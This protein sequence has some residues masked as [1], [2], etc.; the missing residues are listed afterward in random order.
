MTKSLLFKNRYPENGSGMDRLCIGIDSIRMG[1]HNRAHAAKTSRKL[2]TLLFVLFLGIGQMWGDTGTLVSALN[3]I[4]SGDTYYITAL[5]SSKYYTVPKTTIDGQ[6]FTCSEGTYNSTTKKLTPATGA[7]EFVFT[8]VSNVS[9]AYYIY[10]TYLKK[11][12]VATGSK[13]FGY[14]D[15]TSSDYGYWTFSS[16][17]SGGFSGQFSVTHSDKSHY[18]RAYNN[19][20][21]C[22]DGASNNG[23]Y[24]FK[25]DVASCTAPT[26][27]TQPTGASYNKNATPSA[28]S[29]TATGTSLTY[30]WYSN[31]TNSTTG[32]S[33]ISGATSSSYTPSTATAG[34]KYY[35][36]I[37]SSS[38]CTTTS[39]IV[40]V[41]VNVPVSSISL[42]KSSTTIVEDQT[43]TLTA[44]VSP[45]DANNKNVNWSSDDTGV[46]TVNSSG[47][48][49]AKAAGTATITATSAADDTKSAS[50]T[51]TVTAA[52]R[53]HFVDL[54]HSTE[55][56]DQK[57]SYTTPTI[58]DKA[59]ATSGTCEAQHYHFV[60]WITKEKYDDGT[61]ITDGDLQTPT[62]ASNATYYAVWAKGSDNSHTESVNWGDRY[63]ETTDVEGAELSI[64]TSAKVTHNKGTNNTTCKFYTTGPGI[65]VYGGGNF[66]VTT[67]SY[68]SEISL[69][70]GT[71]DGSNTITA[72]T[73]TYSNGSWECGNVSTTSV[74]FS[75]GGSSGNRRISG[76][77]VTYGGTSYSDYIAKCC[78][79]LASIN[80]S[81]KTSN[82][83][84]IVL[85]W[86]KLSGVDGT[87]PYTITCKNGNAD[88]G[89]IGTVDLSGTKATCTV[90]GLDCSTTYTFTITAN[91]DADHCDAT[92]NNIQGTTA[93][94]YSAPTLSYTASLTA[95]GAHANPSWATTPT[96][97]G[98]LTYSSSNTAVLTVNSSTGEVTPVGAGTAH[99]IASWA[100]NDDYC[101][102][103]KNS[104]DITV[105]GNVSVSFNANGGTGTMENQSIQ[106]ST[107]TNLTAN[108]F[109]APNSCKYF[110]GWAT[111]KANAD[112]ETRAYTD[113]QEVTITAGMELFAIW[114]TYNYVVTKGT[115]TGAATFT[116]SAN[117]VD[118]GGS[119]TV[120]AT[121]DA[122]HKG[123][124]QVSI[125]PSTAGEVSG[126]TISNIS[127]AITSVDVTFAAKTVYNI[128]WKVGG[129]ALKDEALENV[130]TS[131][132]EGNGLEFLPTVYDNAV[133]TDLK[134]M[135][136][137]AGDELSGMGNSAP[138]DL[139]TTAGSEPTIEENVTYHAVFAK[140]TAEESDSWDLCET[141]ND[142]TAGDY[143]I[144]WNN[145][146]YLPSETTASKNPA[147]GSGITINTNN[148]ALTNTVTDPMQWTFAGNNSDGW[149][150]RHKKNSTTYYLGAVDDAQGIKIN[151][152]EQSG[153]SYLWTVD[154]NATYGMRLHAAGSRYLA[155]LT[156]DWRNYGTSN[157][158][159]T[160]RLYRHNVSEAAYEDYITKV[161][162]LSSIAV[163][164]APNKTTYKK[165][166]QLDLTNMVV[167]ATYADASTQAVTGYTVNLAET[168]LT[169]SN[170]KFTVTYTEN[171]VTKTTTQA[172]HV[173]ALSGIAITNAP[174]KTVYKKGELVDTE[175]MA[176]QATWGGDATDKIVENNISG[177]TI[178]LNEA[179]TSENTKYTVS[180]TYEEVEQTAEQPIH[181]Y[182]LSGIAVTTPPTKIT[183]N[184]GESFDAT[185]MV[186]TATW[187]GDAQD[188]ISEDVTGYTF[189]TNPLVNDTENNALVDVTVSYTS[190]E[191]TKTTTQQVTVHPIANL[192]MTWD[193][194]G[195]TTTS[196]IY[197]NA[198]DKYLLVLPE[199]DPEVPAGFGAGY[200]FKGWT[201]AVS[202]AKD[203]N[204][205][206]KA[207]AGT[208]MTEATTF[209][210][211]FA[212][213]NGEDAPAGYKLSSSAPAD[214]ETVIIAREVNNKYYAFNKTAGSTELTITDGVVASTTSV[215]W[216]AKAQ[217]N[218]TTATGLFYFVSGQ[219]TNLIHINSSAFN[220]T[221]SAQNGDIVFT[222]NG[223]GTFTAARNNSGSLDR[224]F[225]AKNTNEFGVTSTE[226]SALALY[227]FKYAAAQVATYSNYRFA[228]SNVV[229]PEIALAEGTYYG[230]QNV[231]ISQSQSKPIYYTLDGTNPTNASTL[232]EGAISLNEAGTKT[233]K[234]IA[235]DE[236]T[237]DY[238]ALDEATYTI[239]TEIAA[240]TLTEGGK[241]YDESK[242]VEISHPLTAEGAVIHYSYND[243]SYSTYSSALT[244][245]E[246]KT[247]WA[248]ATIG[249]LTSE[250]VSATYI[251]SSSETYDK[252]TDV[253][254]LAAG[255]EFILYA[256]P[257]SSEYH[258]G[259]GALN[260]SYLG[261]VD[262]T[263]PN[264][265]VLT[266]EGEGVTIFTL[267]GLPD[268]WRILF[269][270]KPL[271]SNAAKNVNFGN[272]GASEWTISI[273]N[274][275]T[276]ITSSTS[277][278]GSLKYNASSPRFTTYASGQTNV[279]IYY[280]EYE[281][282]YS[283]TFDIDGTDKTVKVVDGYEYTITNTT[284]GTAPENS[285]FT[286]KW[287]D[288]SKSYKVG[289]KIT[290][291]SDVTLVPCWEVSLAP[292]TEEPAT[293]TSDDIPTGV[294]DITVGENIT[295]E[296]SSD[297]K[298]YTNITVQDGGTVTIGGTT[299]TEE[300]T[301]ENGGT[302]EVKAETTT[303][304][305]DVK[306][307]GKV[308]INTTDN[309]KLTV[310]EFVI[311]MT[312]GVPSDNNGN[313]ISGQVENAQ[314]LTIEGDAYFDFS[315]AVNVSTQAGA[316]KAAKQWHNFSV[317]FPVDA[318]NGVYNAKTGEK[319]T[320]EVDYAIETYHGDLRANGQYG[321]KKFRG[322]MEPGVTYSMTVNGDIQT[323]RFKKV[324]GSHTF[325]SNPG[326]DF[327]QHASSNTKD[328][329][330]NGL[331]N[332][333]LAY[334][335]INNDKIEETT[336]NDVVGRYVQ[337]LDAV[338]YKYVAKLITDINF[339]VGAAFF[340]QAAANG[341]MEFAG[342]QNGAS[343]AYAPART[344]AKRVEPIEVS[345]SHETGSD[346]MYITANEDAKNEYVIGRDMQ[347]MFATNN[348]TSPL[349]YSVNYGDVQL[350]AEDATLVDDKATYEL[351]FFVP[352]T[353]TYTISAENTGEATIFLTY[354]GNIVWDLT[355]SPYE[356]DLTKGRNDGYGLIMQAKAPQ[357]STG[358]SGTDAE[359]AG[360]Q[361]VVINNHVY[362]LRGGEMYDVT[363]KA[364][365]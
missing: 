76:I 243:A 106:V 184:A 84:S 332:M 208:E 96:H 128:T 333:R 65:R 169:T 146:Y 242:N 133:G 130:T 194:A 285:T 174:T 364:V 26:I 352:A 165:G 156:S 360:V 224:W 195:S 88:A 176:V 207:T 218:T 40:A 163:T 252:L 198:Q 328:A 73:G 291:T 28:L 66:V 15:N 191:V 71:G 308:T 336:E 330:W 175:G 74:T 124:P 268:A 69:S 212:L 260:G 263:A 298:T 7:G 188:A 265:D 99:V 58:E 145:T 180:Y 148:D 228:P 315:L 29:V 177:W 160:L 139:F 327:S 350:S 91:G 98:T 280:K 347:K 343:V 64:G 275:A 127:A 89:V 161:V 266:L 251:K 248:Y 82:Q 234:A 121:P 157:Y 323:Y 312:P 70:F 25:K 129:V 9:N 223:D 217:C 123:D 284:C 68:I 294:T 143:V 136:W 22:Y 27:T 134:F 363:G 61:A 226:S 287:T 4:S 92:Q 349:I 211:V 140:Q 170:D 318:I 256:H 153:N 10:N 326:V 344:P 304:N 337:V 254:Q 147:V 103:S 164:T 215:L 262:L 361:K 55:I 216:D 342:A 250:K 78:T 117:N 39:S 331:G 200:E 168:A 239:V 255:M 86:D 201:S 258:Y 6:T 34:T 322:I 214:G 183:Y 60:G 296:I 353:D 162:A 90:T 44:T 274:E 358:V 97:T 50:C 102:A 309:K 155:V 306:N 115:G 245:T 49:T 112:A 131:V 41:T 235:Y 57:G 220:I 293:I 257:A 230:A 87:T 151:T 23:V 192:T 238:S 93:V 77:S 172:I 276:T 104:N 150:I 204:N 120:T 119:I 193:V 292:T 246:T 247:V 232:Y 152:N 302:I 167:T 46:A 67:P 240:P 278:Y 137:T 16:V 154:V 80:G 53:D 105:V 51:V 316:T 118:C 354:E 227:I 30:Q 94:A 346:A 237:D 341:T 324:E 277:S 203:G 114:K 149:T 187:G 311:E 190:N 299:T 52:P 135:G 101:E 113:G 236:S 13:K 166:E 282:T 37:V 47:V 253:N 199:N 138:S 42:N 3:G 45:N 186:V 179:L 109:T 325:E 181:V 222:A 288:G 21:R 335:S 59:A 348:P 249:G 334:A 359:A 48:V 321:W 356:A 141:E 5:N 205:F 286:D 319:L 357:I 317:P 116:L 85:Q 295:F 206:V 340:I 1:H 18:M 270:D 202:V 271:C 178:N 221:N 189:S 185:G 305:L 289:D 301:V 36:C 56:A 314:N 33:S 95:G 132:Y 244:L 283:L 32:A 43:E 297:D 269:E 182:D 351:R 38:T 24:L 111:S 290:L 83:R 307:G 17:S 196:K 72:N 173:Y 300:I 303:E 31:T 142:V 122:T 338:E 20:V 100:Q 273:A 272:N 345:I 225:A 267:A 320:N 108:A 158:N 144:T 261:K 329:G 75:V 107:P 209:H 210:A 125:T 126:T 14:V 62:S 63:T 313:G 229:A 79:E 213:K 110:Y 281:T 279:D 11:Y 264:G 362:I 219:T 19:S 35:Y 241:F 365:K 197:I 231:T 159:G 171:N 81:V 54:V 310:K 259:A 233:I 355:I 8:A 2:F 339:T 12:L